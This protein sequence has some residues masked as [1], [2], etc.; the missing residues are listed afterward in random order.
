M[1]KLRSAQTK[2]ESKT[3][4]RQRSTSTRTRK[5]TAANDAQTLVTIAGV[6]A[7]V[8]TTH[9]ALSLALKASQRGI[10]CAVI[11]PHLS[12]E[13]LKQYYVLSVREDKSEGQGGEPRQFATFA[14]LNIMAGILPGDLE[15]FQL[16][17]WDCGS[18]PL[19][20]RRFSS[21][22]LCC[23]LSGG[24]AWEL[25]P[26]NALLAKLSYEELSRYLVCIRAVP[27]SDFDHIVEQMAGKL[28]CVHLL[29]KTNWGDVVLREDLIAI[30]RHA[31]C[32]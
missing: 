18:L 21:G 23:L 25:A 10:S 20:Q 31:Q 14:G 9:L 26:L 2:L 11:I 19:G 13:A 12:F 6:E 27:E 29:H 28:P 24:Q 5:P 30:L 22:D 17:V 7:K 3:I 15:G 32:C 1:L 4:T 16:I 8:G